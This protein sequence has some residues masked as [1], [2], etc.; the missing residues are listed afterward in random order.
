MGKQ[1][2][3]YTHFGFKKVLFANKSK[4][5]ESVFS[6]VSEKYDLMNDLMS[7]GLHRVWKREFLKFLSDRSASLLDLAG[8]SGDIA[9]HY[10]TRPRKEG[11][12]PYI[13]L[14][15][16]N[17]DMLNVARARLID[18]GL[19]SGIDL[20]AG[21]AMNIPCPDNSFDY[22]TI[23]FGIRNVS[24]IEKVIQES[25]R[26]L[27][28]GGKF[29]CMEFSHVEKAIFSKIYDFYS[30]NIIPKLGKFITGNEDAYQYLVESIRQF[31]KKEEFLNMLDYN[32]FKATGYKTLTS[33]VVAIHYGYKL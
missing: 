32:A 29:I 17:V 10:L 27:K 12:S 13:A 7:V 30:F 24:D 26:I 4:L 21:D 2:E 1:E 5:V 11:K 22:V 14:C 16:I 28:P 31:P 18:Q 15:D 33:G 23:V 20:I 19:P 25:Y 6:A 9:Y 3:K 8:G